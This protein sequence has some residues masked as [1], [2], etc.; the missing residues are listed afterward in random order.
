MSSTA[1]VGKLT[2]TAA[3]QPPSRHHHPQWDLNIPDVT[4]QS[5]RT[6]Y[7]VTIQQSQ[8]A[9][10]H[11]TIQQSQRAPYHV[12]IQQ[13]Q[14]APYHVTIQQSQRVPLPCD[15]TTVSEGALTM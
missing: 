10:Y 5:Q 13:S 3:T 4:Q 12:T 11:V 14:R 7:H 8:R 9:P 6:P 15:H 1:A 2:S